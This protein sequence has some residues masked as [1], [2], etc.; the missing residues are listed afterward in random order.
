VGGGLEKG[1]SL[2]RKRGQGIAPEPFHKIDRVLID[3]A[4]TKARLAITPLPIVNDLPPLIRSGDKVSLSDLE[5]G[6]FTVPENLPVACQRLYSN[7]AG[8]DVTLD[9]PDFPDFSS[10]IE[11]SVNTPGAYGHKLLQKKAD[12]GEFGKDIRGTYLRITIGTDLVCEL[13]FG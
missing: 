9:T 2:S 5:G 11:Y 8:V 13:V 6:Q 3:L 1:S 7:V 4:Q 12:G 10:A